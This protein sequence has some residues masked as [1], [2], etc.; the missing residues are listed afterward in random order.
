[1]GSIPIE[2][3]EDN[4]IN[5]FDKFRKPGETFDFLGITFTVL[6]TKVGSNA[7]GLE[8][9]PTTMRTC[10]VK[11]GRFFR[12]AFSLGELPILQ[13]AD[14]KDVP[15]NDVEPPCEA[16]ETQ[17]PTCNSSSEDHVLRHTGTGEGMWKIMCTKCGTTVRGYNPE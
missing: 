11:D 14:T 5:P 15:I 2:G 4:M 9:E 6:D 10:Y 7:F 12:V 17:C 8:L 3:S 13:A 16:N 1:M